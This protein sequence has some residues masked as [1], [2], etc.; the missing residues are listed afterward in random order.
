MLM[1]KTT[2]IGCYGLVAEIDLLLCLVVTGNKVYHD[3]NHCFSIFFAQLL[4]I[5]C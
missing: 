4:R 2:K 3:I 1:N 5:L